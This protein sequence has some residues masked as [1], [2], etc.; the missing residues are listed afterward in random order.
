[1]Q[2]FQE[3]EVDSAV[4]QQPL[5]DQAA[6]HTFPYA[7]D[8]SEAD[9][10][11]QYVSVN[12][13][14]P[15][16]TD[17]TT[18]MGLSILSNVLSGSPGAPLRRALTESGLGEDTM[19]GGFANHLRQPMFSTG[20]KGVDKENIPAVEALIDETLQRLVTEGIDPAAIEASLNTV[21][22]RLREANTGSYPRGLVHMLGALGRWIYDGDPYEGLRYEGPLQAVKDGIAQGNFFESLIG[23]YLLENSHRTTVI[24]EPDADLS[25]RT[26]SEELEKLTAAKAAMSNDELEAIIANTKALKERQERPDTPEELALLPSLTLADLEKE[27]KPLPIDVAQHGQAKV[28]SHDLFTNGIVYFRLGMNMRVLPADLLPYLPL[29]SYALTEIGTE[30]ED[31]VQLAQRIGRLTGGV[32]ASSQVSS[33]RNQKE[34]LAW[35]W[36]RGKATMERAQDLLDIIRDVLL[37]VK[38]DNRERFQQMVLEE[39]S[40]QESSLVPGGHVVAMTRLGAHF[41]EAGWINEETNGI[42]YLFFLRR[43]LD[44]VE[45]DWPSVLA[46]LE[47]IRT[48][49][50][51]RD[52]M[53]CDTTL[54]SERYATFEPLIH[55]LIDSFPAN[56]VIH[57][58][59]TPT[60]LP[61]NEGLTIPAQVN[62]VAKAVNLFEHGFTHHGSVAVITK[63]MGTGYLWEKIRMQGGAYGAFMPYSAASGISSFCS[64]RDP[65]LSDTLDVYDQAADYLAQLPLTP[66]QIEKAVIGVIG[67]LDSYQLPDAKGYTSLN[68][69]LNGITDSY[70]QQRRD[71]VLGTTIGDFQ[72]FAAAL[73][74]L[75]EHGH[76]VVVGSSEAIIKA[77]DA[78]PPSQ[79]LTLTKLM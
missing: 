29:F 62:Y 58:T 38:L 28:I 1:M 5:R 7:I 30:T 24:L 79:Q 46:K 49:L 33:V 16:V 54:D 18:Q 25:K 12:W 51:N 67:D 64:Y 63:M 72:S 50:V 60:E 23:Q 77:N 15:E 39:K 9:N 36:I 32:G 35:L 57:Q 26:E 43:L 14:L 55:N 73:Q 8:P 44:D 21:E 41:T 11:K 40:G 78:L 34:A 45:N 47:Q 74:V 13:L 56:E 10:A 71:E 75:K 19:G 27:V 6:R 68:R 53:L 31:Y 76:T 2:D 61:R 70:R 42:S 22:F 17:L 20:L 66:T 59:W 69:Y 37:T 48:L 4:P 65:N 3:I 52:N